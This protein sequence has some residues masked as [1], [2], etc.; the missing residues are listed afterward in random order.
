MTV[1]DEIETCIPA[2]RRYAHALLRD[3]EGAED[4]V[5]DC[6]ERAVARRTLWR[7]DGP[8]RAWLFRILLNRFRD[9]RRSAEGRAQLVPLDATVEPA[10][11]GGQEA[12]LD[13][14]EVHA[15]MGR[16][17][18]DQRA[19]LLLV[20]L[21]GM[22]LAEAA[23]VLDIPEGT[24]TSRLARARETLRRMTGRAPAQDLVERK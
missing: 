21:E 18:F 11:S 4:L 20:A 7:G 22:S 16:L 19:A 3:R 6:L 12:H 13:L 23:R 9:V 10:R 1:L 17:P 8:V 15:A 2:L 5:Q 14:R 24:L